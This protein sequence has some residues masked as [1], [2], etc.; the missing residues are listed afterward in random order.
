[1]AAP[2]SS[3]PGLRVLACG[4]PDAAATA[5][6]PPLADA[7]IAVEPHQDPDTLAA[8]PQ[9][10][11]ADA[12]LLALPNADAALAWPALLP[13]A[14]HTAVLLLLPQPG[15]DDAARLAAVGVQDLLPQAEATP[16]RLALALRLA[17]A[18]KRLETATRRAYAT[19]LATGLPNHAQLLEH[20]THLLAL[21]E[22]EPAPMALI[23]LRLQGL[24]Q[25]AA[26]LGPEAAQVLRRKAAVRLRAGLRASDVVAS[27]GADAFAV[28]LAWMD[29]PADAERVLA[30]LVQSLAQPFT[31]T[32]RPQALAVSAGLAHH[33]DHGRQ[34]DA[35]LHRA[36]AQAASMAAVGGSLPAQAA[37]RGPDAAA[38][39]EG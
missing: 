24:A 13:A 38:N 25:T 31:V 19:D 32:G 27:L 17:V 22:R 11:Q 12:W 34:A 33:P 4:L 6:R 8:A 18:R 1:M 37:D 29:A 14:L 20:M 10:L 2:A 9:A 28:L 16:A 30:K 36:L 5:L 15:A 7:G 23:V 3:A 21:R 39:D 26:A 35:L